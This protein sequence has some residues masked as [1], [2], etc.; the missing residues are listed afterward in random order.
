[1]PGST[2]HA[3]WAYKKHTSRFQSNASS[4]PTHA[5]SLVSCVTSC[6]GDAHNASVS[7]MHA[8]SG[9]QTEH[10][11]LSNSFSMCDMA[12]IRRGKG[13]RQ[14]KV[15]AESCVHTLKTARDCC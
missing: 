15:S 14:E 9:A 6:M 13:L 5:S 4:V 11:A 2:A 12:K 7:Q 3:S 10:I 8:P 1:M